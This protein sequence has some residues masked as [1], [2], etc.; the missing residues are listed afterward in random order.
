[1]SPIYRH[2]F[3]VLDTF[4]DVNGHVNNVVYIQWMQDIAKLHS[5]TSGCTHST[6]KAGAIW[7]VRSHKVEYLHPA[8]AGDE[9]EVL[10]WV[11]N[12]RRVRSL[13]RYKFIRP[14]D[15]T[16][17]AKGE[18]DWV[19]VDAE[20]GQLRSIPDKVTQAFELLPQDQEP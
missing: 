19:F 7:V 5:D 8:L 9:I 6:R 17:L 3:T 20:T 10:T 14:T 15:N 1:M 2:R 13:R 18:T 12:L 4:V 16:L 11:V